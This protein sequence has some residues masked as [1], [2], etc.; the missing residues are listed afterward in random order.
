M[1]PLGIWN[2]ESD[3]FVIAGHC[4]NGVYAPLKPIVWEQELENDS[5]LEYLLDGV[6]DGFKLIDCEL[7]LIKPYETDNPWM[8]NQILTN[9]SALKSFK[10]KLIQRRKKLLVF[11]LMVY[12][13]KRVPI[14]DCSRPY[15]RI[16]ND[17]IE[18]PSMKFSTVDIA[19]K[20][21]KPGCYFA[22]VDILKAY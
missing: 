4:I 13:Q 5:D 20:R 15:A 19:I 6:F 1:F 12:S 2:H 9:S 21:M 11:T 16:I 22:A 3:D 14:T 18:Y 7:S 8:Q 10:L 17:Q